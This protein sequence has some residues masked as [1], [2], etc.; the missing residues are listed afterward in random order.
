[1]T[2]LPEKEDETSDERDADD[3]EEGAGHP[4]QN[5][6]SHHKSQAKENQVL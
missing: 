3:L 1:V 2:T 4:H 6:D 5:P